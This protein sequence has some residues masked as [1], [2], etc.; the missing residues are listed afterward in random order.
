[1]EFKY[2]AYIPSTDSFVKV[3]QLTTKDYIELVKYITNADP[4]ALIEAYDDVISQLTNNIDVKSLTRVDK[5]FI[6]LTIR[7]I[8]VGPLLSMTFEDV[9]STKSYTSHVELFPVMQR[10]ADIE[11]EFKRCIKI[12]NN[13]S[14]FIKLPSS[15]YIEDSNDLLVECIDSIKIDNYTHN[16]SEFTINEKQQVVNNL[17]GI[18]MVDLYKYINDGLE[19]FAEV[20][21]FKKMN[22]HNPSENEVYSVN[23]FDTSMYNFINLCYNES[24]NYIRDI[25]YILQRKCNFSG[26]I[27]HNSTF[28]EIRMYIDLYEEEIRERE[29][30]E[31]K[32]QQNQSRSSP[33]GAPSA[34]NSF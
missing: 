16:L 2:S 5:F 6:L 10:I 8:C 30:A 28:A 7:A 32:A 22:P 33:I 9:K 3:G 29:K 20:N 24:L 21:L 1:M 11:Y 26:E 27:L 34:P 17:P 4:L 13:I 14:V 12:T 19:K 18:L 15:L 31:Q 23:I 25:M